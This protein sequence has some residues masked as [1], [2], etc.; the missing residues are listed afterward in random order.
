M[1]IATGQPSHRTES[2]RLYCELTAMLPA[3][4]HCRLGL[5]SP[6]SRAKGSF[7]FYPCPCGWYGDPVTAR[8]CSES[9]VRHQGMACRY[10]KR[11]SGPLLDRVD[12][13]SDDIHMDVPRV[14]AGS[15]SHATSCRMTAWASPWQRFGGQSGLLAKADALGNARVGL[16]QVRKVCAAEVHEERF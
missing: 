8:T 15:G 14:E 12:R 5:R 13:R 6:G 16:A 7:C 2:Q 4:H 9:M 10:Q 11:I 1:P 3:H